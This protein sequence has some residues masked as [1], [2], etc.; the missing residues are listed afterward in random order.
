VA[1]DTQ[2]TLTEGPKHAPVTTTESPAEAATVQR[3]AAANAGYPADVF[4]TPKAADGPPPSHE[5]SL[6][7]LQGA[8]KP[9]ADE[10]ARTGKTPTG[11]E[12]DAL[13]KRAERIGTNATP[14]QQPPAN[15]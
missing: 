1:K 7:A 15:P 11:P 12:R 10:Y 13:V 9:L 5:E 8:P 4:E 3:Q 2:S 6:G 14:E